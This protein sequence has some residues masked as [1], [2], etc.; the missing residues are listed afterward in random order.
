MLNTTLEVAME[1]FSTVFLHKGKL[2]ALA[3]MAIILSSCP[4]PI[5]PT[6]FPKVILTQQM[7]DEYGISSTE[8]Q[9]IPIY[10][11]DPL[12]LQDGDTKRGKEIIPGQ[13]INLRTNQSYGRLVLQ[14]NIPGKV[15][16]GSEKG[17][18]GG[19]KRLLRVQFQGPGNTL[20]LEFS[21]DSGGRYRLKTESGSGG[22]YI[23]SGTKK[24]LCLD[25]YTNNFLLVPAEE[26]HKAELNTQTMGRP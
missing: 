26:I 17:S 22:R 7:I 3:G 18:F 10:L 16:N 14:S 1:I 12:V 21:P 13:G 9:Q 11:A 6:V 5:K 8:L 4:S 2:A 15:L 24:Y 19:R 23:K 20:T 25:H